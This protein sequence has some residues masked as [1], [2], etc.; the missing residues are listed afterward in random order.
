MHEYKYTV[1]LTPAAY[2]RMEEHI[3]FL[4]QASISGA[5]R[6]RNKLHKEVTSLD[7][8]PDGYP[9]Y[10]TSK[11]TDITYHYTLCPKTHRIV[12]RVLDDTVLVYD[13]QD[14]RQHSNKSL[15]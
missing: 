5:T 9:C 12:F 6:L 11:S 14:C 8:N 7:F 4:A 15:V 13:V 1:H 2:N 3:I 10:F